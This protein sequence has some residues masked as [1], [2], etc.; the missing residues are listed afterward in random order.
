MES[1]YWP[2]RK[3]NW[4]M[5]VCLVVTLK[6]FSPL[7]SSCLKWVSKLPQR[8]ELF[9]EYRDVKKR[10]AQE[11]LLQLL[12]KWA[13]T[14]SFQQ[15][16]LSW[17]WTSQL[18]LFQDLFQKVK[19]EYEKQMFLPFLG[20]YWVEE[21][22]GSQCCSQLHGFPDTQSVGFNFQR[23]MKLSAFILKKANEQKLKCQL[24]VSNT[25][26]QGRKT[27]VLRP[28]K[29]GQVPP[30]KM[31]CDKM[32][33]FLNQLRTLEDWFTWNYWVLLMPLSHCAG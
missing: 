21:K 14:V 30:L 12:L 6:L 19:I 8:A 23:S 2:E 24:T 25:T 22:V 15:W 4:G 7:C 9:S 27:W 10:T 13:E 11:V 32:V 33:W 29:Q 18:H 1:F 31:A 26:E 20:F 5:F 16:K 28:Q 17:S 3:L